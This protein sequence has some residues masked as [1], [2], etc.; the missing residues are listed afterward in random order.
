M[1]SNKILIVDDDRALQEQLAW[2]LKH[3]FE[4]VQC[5]DRDSALQAAVNEVPDL[6]LLDLHLPPTNL[7]DDGLKNI[8]EIRRAQPEAV[9]IVMTGDEETGTPLR[10]VE[11]GAYDYF[12][13]PIDLP[14]LRIIINRALER[15]RIE[16][17][18]VRLRK[19]IES[20]YSFSTILGT[21]E[22]MIEV[23]EAI[24]RVADS[25]ATVIL[26]GESGTGKELVAK[27]I[28]YNSGRRQ[29][30]FVSVNCAALP[31]GLI[32]A[33]LFG[34]EKGAFTGALG[35]VEG[36]F[37]RA[38]G[39][40]LL[41]DEIGA[42]GLPLQS[43]L[44]R[45]LEE[46][47]VTRVGGKSPI[48][49][50]IRLISATNENL[51]DAVSAGRFREDLYYRINV[52]PI[53][54]PPLR[55]RRE[56]I[57]LLIEHFIRRFSEEHGPRKHIDTEAL[58]YL[59]DY[60]WKGNVR[61][62]ENLIQQVVLMTD[63]ETISASHLPPHILNQEPFFRPAAEGQSESSIPLLPDAGLSLDREV[64]RYEY[65]LVRSALAR[66]GGVKIKA[67]ELLG[68]NKDRM[69]YLCKKY[70]L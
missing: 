65:E 39:G 46:R 29:G 2:A 69:K 58:H 19:E 53:N 12:R 20:R 31:E 9:V 51:E 37:E 7:L 26:R 42:L 24:R 6:V 41:L 56:D 18:N 35:L 44:L 13:K 70:D 22:P 27:A 54:L 23:F 49:V 67:A 25:S 33:E 17:E 16:R 66:A 45:V 4:L 43:K 1:P 60:S 34:H 11:E 63:S 64:A 47:E 40:T 61:E 28:H 30:P 57:P 36:R 3:D 52:V 38:H 8:G 5:L 55:D 32:E 14:E 48:K 68:L 21:S 62:L 50:D 59:M 15:Q 10:A